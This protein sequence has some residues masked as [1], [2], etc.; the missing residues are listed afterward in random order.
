MD[1]GILRLARKPPDWRSNWGSRRD[2][3]EIEELT[4][5]GPWPMRRRDHE[6][7]LGSAAAGCDGRPARGCPKR[8]RVE[9]RR[10]QVHLLFRPVLRCPMLL[11]FVSAAMPHLLQAGVRHMPGE[12]VAHVLPNRPGNRDEAGLQDLL[13]RRVQDL[14]QAVL[15][16]MLQDLR[17]DLLQALLPDLLE[18]VPLHDLQ[19]R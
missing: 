2:G 18:R 12:A 9:L 14:L 6:D 17:A 7:A 3:P 11:H 8:G 10:R 15:P 16:N 5:P 4:Q 1:G 19:T 13:S